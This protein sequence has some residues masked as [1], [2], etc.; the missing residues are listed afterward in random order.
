MGCMDT[1]ATA[2]LRRRGRPRLEHPR[3]K[4]NS[5]SVVFTDV[6]R[7]E[8]EEAARAAYKPLRVF[9]RLKALEALRLTHHTETTSTG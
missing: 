7:A 8:F 1:P 3:R 5:I 4:E 2:P 6:E 9:V